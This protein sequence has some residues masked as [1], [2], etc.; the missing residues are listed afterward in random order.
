[1]STIS[2]RIFTQKRTPAKVNIGQALLAKYMD[3]AKSQDK[4]GILWFMKVVIAIPCVFMVL[5]IFVMAMLTP[6][7]I[8]FVALSMLLFFL[9]VIVHI[10]ETKSTFYV[11]LYHITVAVFL[12]IP[13]ITYLIK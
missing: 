2:K 6:N 10:A 13:F 7:Y 4:A 11:P 1:M 3:Y 9:N 12:L 8:W 5:S